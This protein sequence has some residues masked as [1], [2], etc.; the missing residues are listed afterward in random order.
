MTV[1]NWIRG[2]AL[3]DKISEGEFAIYG[4]YP[5]IVGRAHGG[6][7]KILMG[8]FESG[9][10]LIDAS[11]A[12]ARHQNNAHSLAWA[13]GIAAQTSQLQHEP[14]TTARFAS[15]AIDIARDRT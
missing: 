3:A 12:H 7:A 5:S 10:R 1:R 2:A 4:I 8:F 14:A 13:L 9:M 11:I 6:Q 15:E